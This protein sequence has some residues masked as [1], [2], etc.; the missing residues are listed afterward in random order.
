MQNTPRSVLPLSSLSHT[1]PCNHQQ[2]ICEG[3]VRLLRGWGEIH[4]RCW[5]HYHRWSGDPREDGSVQRQTGRLCSSQYE[6]LSASLLSA[7]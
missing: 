4:Q 3:G 6:F 5:E 7:L 1:A 2:D